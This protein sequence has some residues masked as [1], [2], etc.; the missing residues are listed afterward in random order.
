[1]T[2]RRS[3]QQEYIY[4][5][6]L[7]VDIKLKQNNKGL[8]DAEYTDCDNQYIFHIQTRANRETPSQALHYLLKAM[9]ERNINPEYIKELSTEVKIINPW[10]EIKLANKNQRLWTISTDNTNF[11]LLENTNSNGQK[12]FLVTYDNNNGS[13]VHSA[14]VKEPKTI[15]DALDLM[16]KILKENTNKD[17]YYELTIEPEELNDLD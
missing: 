12:T 5:G 15:M 7:P 1:M 11:S 10:K 6:S 9:K 13:T 4:F 14:K 16:H 17:Y 2:W 8:W 3:P